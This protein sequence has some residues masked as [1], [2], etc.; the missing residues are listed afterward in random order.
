VFADPARAK[1]LGWELHSAPDLPDTLIGDAQRLQQVLGN[2]LSNAIKFTAQGRVSLR[3]DRVELDAQR[4]GLRFQVRDSGI[5]IAP[6]AQAQLFQPFVQAEAS[7]TRRFGGTGLGLS[8]VKHL[9][10][11]MDGTVALESQPGQGSVFTVELPLL[12]AAETSRHR[13]QRLEAVIVE[14]EELQRDRLSALCAGFGWQARSFAEAARLAGATAAAP[15]SR[16][17]P[18]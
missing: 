16:S 12:E 18:A 14:D 2:L 3:V 8:I 15:A 1:G 10:G 4:P 5:G 11:L 7:T 9:V 13:P 17:G 6:E